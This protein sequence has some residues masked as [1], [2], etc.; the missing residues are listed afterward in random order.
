M[1]AEEKETCYRS[2]F[3]N[4]FDAILLTQ[5]DGSILSANPAACRMFGMTEE[6]LTGMRWEM[7]VVDDEKLDRALRGRELRGTATAKLTLK[8]KEGTTF[9]GEVT[10]NLFT[11]AVGS[12]RASMIIRDITERQ[13]AEEMLHDSE[14]KFAK[15]FY[16]N[17]SAMA[18]MR[19]EDGCILDAN[20]RWLA[21]YGCIRSEII[22]RTAAEHRLWYSPEERKRML[23][24]LQKQGH[25]RDLEFKFVRKNGEV[26]IGLMSSQMIMLHGEKVVLTSLLDIT[27]RKKAEKALKESE[28][29]YRHLFET[30]QE[31]FYIDRLLYDEQGKVIDWIFED[32]N[33]A[34]FALL[35]LGS[36][37]EAKGRRGS[38]VLGRKAASFY[39][40]M[41][42][43][44]RRSSEAV[45]FQ[46]SSPC[47]DKDFITSYVVHGDLLI[48]AQ[49]DITAIK[50]A[51]MAVGESEQRLRTHVENS[52][53]A[54]MEWDANFIVTRW[55]GEAEKLFG[56]SPEEVVGKPIM[57]LNLVYPEDIP[58]VE[59][60]MAKLT[61]GVSVKVVSSNRNFSKDGRVLYCTWYN[62]V[63]YDERGRM[64]SVL[65]LVLDNTARVK[66]EEDLKRSNVELQQFAYV[67][68]HDLQEPLRMVTTYL[69]LLN[70]KYGDEL[71][72]RA[73][74]YMAYAVDGAERM[75]GLINDLLQYSRIETQGMEFSAV[76][77]NQV[78]ERVIDMMHL[79]IKENKAV[80]TVKH[81]PTVRG[82]ATQLP[83]LLQNLISN[84]IKFHGPEPP[85]VEISAHH[86]YYEWIIAV[87]DNGI[88]IDPKYHDNL[89]KMFHRLHT[90]REYPGTGIGLAISK[91]IVERHGGRIW[92]ESDGKN[93]ST[94]YF[95]I[96]V[97]S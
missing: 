32:M 26:W 68:S 25:F 45:T 82:D 7:I 60:T 33:P 59:R 72:D 67:A 15:A 16:G 50:C 95:T 14:E 93:G 49:M 39:L 90:E 52:P 12:T 18:I 55:A 13:R 29:K 51:Q 71:N 92:V 40:P 69:G 84:A 6:E 27:K 63:I 79:S 86:R 73:K 4:S 78:A 91:K 2:L 77:L 97:R 23:S 70:K 94:F 87:K 58:I 47:V 35:G 46:Y 85:I 3:E 9:V 1:V 20:E 53:M 30:V 81:L 43:E 21:F 37:E 17:V 65:S 74:G 66:A 61:D 44:A 42:E 64:S 75:R 56:W 38:E 10:T 54:V 80:V 88:G 41:I 89:F 36:I 19:L 5:P 83:Q 48:S 57:G 22:G 28:E 96:P 24:E 31:V 34:G 62:T 11:D 76:D 8:R